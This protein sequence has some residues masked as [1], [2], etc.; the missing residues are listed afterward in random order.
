MSVTSATLSL[1]PQQ[2]QHLTHRAKIYINIHWLFEIIDS[3]K[4]WAMSYS[5]WNFSCTSQEKNIFFYIM[6]SENF[7][8]VLLLSKFTVILISKY[9]FNPE[10]FEVA[11][12]RECWRLFPSL[13]WT[14]DSLWIMLL[15]AINTDTSVV[16]VATILK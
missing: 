1:I 12:E 7:L 13:Y 4:I 9:M 11:K 16:K 6:L 8:H 14:V 2:P 5:W 3:C 15:K 10:L